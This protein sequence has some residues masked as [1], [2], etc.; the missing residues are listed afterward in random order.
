MEQSQ[1]AFLAAIAVV[2]ILDTAAL[3][4]RLTAR[5]LTRSRYWLDDLMATLAYVSLCCFHIDLPGR[6]LALLISS[7]SQLFCCGNNALYI[8]CELPTHLDVIFRSLFPL[9]TWTDPILP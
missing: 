7:P 8:I 6:N 4:G 5:R 1:E 3:A 9:W 2:W